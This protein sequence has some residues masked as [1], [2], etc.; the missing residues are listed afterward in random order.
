MK[1][2]TWTEIENGYLRRLSRW[3]ESLSNIGSGSRDVV[4]NEQF[5]GFPDADKQE[6][7]LEF[8]VYFRHSE[9]K[10]NGK[11]SVNEGNEVEVQRRNKADETESVPKNFN[12]PENN[13]LE[14]STQGEI[15]QTQI[16]RGPGRPKILKTGRPGRPK[17]L[18]NTKRD[19]FDANPACDGITDPTVGEALARPY[20]SDWREAM[21]SEFNALQESNAWIL[22]TRP[23]NRRIIG[24]LWVLWIKFNADGSAERRKA[25]LVAKGF[26]Q[27]PAVDFQ[28]TFAPVARV[29]LIRIL[30]ALAAELK[31]V[32]YQVDVVMAYVNGDLEEEIFMEQTDGFITVGRGNGLIIKK[33]CV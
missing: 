3:F 8:E 26:S 33:I 29:S 19:N 28:E 5:K 9:I 24:C 25:Q 10:P 16:K 12:N 20:A 30:A 23:T 14:E 31:L 18:F 6:E 32:L 27:L 11:D 13:N 1:K 7:F 22:V 21:K 4:F 17:K 15:Q 2:Q